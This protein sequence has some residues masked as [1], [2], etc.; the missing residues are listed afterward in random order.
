MDRLDKIGKTILLA[1][2]FSA[3]LLPAGWDAA[4]GSEENGGIAGDW[5]THYRSA[6]S[7]GLG[8]SFTALADEPIG[9]IWNPAGL[10]QLFSNEVY[11]ETAR[12][13]EGTSVN[14][15]SFAVPGR[16]FPSLGLSILTMSSGTFERTNE[17][18]DVTGSFN[19]SDMAFVLSA[20]HDFH[21][22]IS[23][24][25]NVKVVRQS[26]DEYNDTGLGL[27]L[28]MLFKVAPRLSLGASLLN[29]GG[30]SL[31]LR[32]T[33]ES[34][35]VE[36]RGGFALQVLSGR[37]L[38]TAEIVH[39]S[40]VE[41]SFHG[42]TEYWVN[43][44]MA[45]RLGLDAMSPS[46]GLRCRLPREIKLDYGM[47]NHELGITHRFS[48]GYAFG[49]FFARSSADPSVFSPFGGRSATKFHLSSK[50]RK[51]VRDWSLALTDKYEHEVRRFGGK[52]TPPA[53]VMWDGKADTGV[54]LPDGIY[55][56]RLTVTDSDGRVVTGET[57]TV[58]I[59]TSISQVK[60]PV[61]V[62]KR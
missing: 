31:S 27:D 62:D 12:L 10:T 33:D 20:S 9:M 34:Y 19:E 29:I 22:F 3:W 35:P 39:L 25:A 30:P 18:N 37:A 11:V 51:E 58:E 54:S 26:L 5:L 42:G 13:F 4:L 7:L 6:R 28:G 36:F 60:V 41:T 56:Y 2:L 47:E 24:G 44:N 55:V 23:A 49:G 52:G 59:D 43:Q 45:L 50:T 32:D 38:V 21:P 16:K 14:S 61:V 8:G 53:H 46:G 15:F 1:A 57:G 17:F 40:G 48:L